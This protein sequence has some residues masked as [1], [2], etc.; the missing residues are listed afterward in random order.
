MLPGRTSSRLVEGLRWFKGRKKRAVAGLVLAAFAALNLLAYFHARAMTI[1]SGDGVRTPRPERLSAWDK[2]R[3]LLTGVNLPRPANER[4]PDDLGLAYETCRIDGERGL[5][6]EAWRI[7]RDRSSA[8]VVMFH[9]YASCKGRLLREARG[10][11]E[12][13]CETLLVDF[14]GSGGSSG[15][16]TT[17]GVFEA[18]DVRSAFEFAKP[19]AG[20]RPIVLYGRSMGSA[21]VLRAV[22]AAGIDPAAVILE[23]PFDRLLTTVENRCRAMRVQSFPLAP[24]LVFWGSVQHGMN[25]FDHN[26]VEYAERVRCPTLLMH[27]GLDPRVSLDEARSVH[28]RLAGQKRFVVFEEAGHES[29]AAVDP[30]RWRQSVADFLAAMLAHAT[31]AP[32]MNSRRE[33]P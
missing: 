17:L 27:G 20:E 15:N 9:G 30:E 21:A 25:G 22:A 8:M 1:F 31:A 12:L 32:E 13:G 14:R 23:C 11:H 7:P 4:T 33:N 6:L 19:L 10:F 3:V 26:P 2:A 24:L 29:Y 5:A 16:E 18:D 28:D